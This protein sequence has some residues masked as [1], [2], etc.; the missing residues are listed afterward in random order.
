VASLSDPELAQGIA[1]NDSDAIQTFVNRFQE[2]IAAIAC[3]RGVPASDCQDVAQEVLAYA[4]RQI[5]EG[6]FRGDATLATWLYTIVNGKI[7][8]FR[9]KRT[10][11]GVSLDQHPDLQHPALVRTVRNDDVLIVQQALSRLSPEDQLVLWLHEVERYTL[12]EIGRMMSL[13]KSAVFDRL[14]RARTRFREAVAGN[15]PANRRLKE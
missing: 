10:F 4:I 13:R 6:R 1:A 14:G 5:A 2:R 8:D 12:A 15:S 11:A 7:A 3:R 9:R